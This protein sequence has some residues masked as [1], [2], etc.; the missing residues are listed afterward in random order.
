M[1]NEALQRDLQL[2]R[3]KRIYFGHQSVGFDVMKGVRELTASA[4]ESSPVFV[5]A[6]TAVLPAG[7][8]F[9]DSRIGRNGYPAEKCGAFRETVTRLERDSL[10]IA[11]MKFCYA[12]ISPGTD[13]AKVFELYARTVDSLKRAFPATVFV[14]STIPYTLKT[15]WWKLLAKRILG[16][17]DHS[18]AGNLQRTR[19]NT[20]L[21]QHYGG[22]PVFDIARVESTHPDGRREA[23][24]FEG[25]TAF[26]LIGELTH[27]GGH[28]NETGRRLAAREFLRVLAAAGAR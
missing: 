23:F 24:S 4:P 21:A 18:Q 27:D 1:D 6:D 11:I 22:D 20:L 2:L 19:F 5:S 10:D 17:E 12:D 25:E 7:G 3:G 15:S 8:W 14:H 9:A 16:R 26:S 28:L 13:P